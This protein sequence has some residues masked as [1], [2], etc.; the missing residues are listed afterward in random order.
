MG[1]GQWSKIRQQE[2]SDCAMSPPKILSSS[3]LSSVSHSPSEFSHGGTT[4][5][6]FTLLLQSFFVFVSPRKDVLMTKSAVCSWASPKRV[7]SSLLTTLKTSEK[8]VL[9]C[10]VNWMVQLYPTQ[11]IP[12]TTWIHFIYWKLAPSRF[13]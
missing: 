13:H 1:E 11:S 2:K 4:W 8:Q 7:D 6:W 9:L 5:Q 12:Y 3:T 10:V